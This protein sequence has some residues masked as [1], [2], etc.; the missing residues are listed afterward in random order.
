MPRSAAFVAG[1]DG[2]P[3]VERTL[4]MPGTFFNFEP[5]GVADWQRV[6]TSKLVDNTY[7]AAR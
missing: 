5:K 2:A 1:E 6:G 4:E 3:G 7:T